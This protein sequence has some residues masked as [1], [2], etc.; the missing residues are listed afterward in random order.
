M[1][2]PA[3]FLAWAII[4]FVTAMVLYAFRGSA[5]TDPEQWTRFAQYT[6]WTTVG[7]LC[8]TASLLIT[9]MFFARR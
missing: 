1:S 7:V 2:L 8:L 4:A 9:S 5:A 6:K 3:V